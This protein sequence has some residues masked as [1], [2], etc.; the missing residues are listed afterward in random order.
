[1]REQERWLLVVPE[2]GLARLLARGQGRAPLRDP[3]RM[4]LQNPELVPVRKQKRRLLRHEDRV[5]LRA[6]VLNRDR[7]L[8]RLN[9]RAQARGLVMGPERGQERPLY[10]V[11]WRRLLPVPKQG[12]LKGQ[13][14]AQLSGGREKLGQCRSQNADTRS[15]NSLKGKDLG[16]DGGGEVR[17]QK[18]RRKDEG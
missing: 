18:A 13:A 9:E 16:R 15:Q 1:V 8:L 2:Q 3:K 6:Q 10:P 11:P 4:L 12:P 5:Q 17:C 7:A 14:L